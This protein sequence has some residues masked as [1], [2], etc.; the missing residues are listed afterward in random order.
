MVVDVAAQ[1][2][3]DRL[4]V[5]QR[6]VVGA[7]D[8]VEVV[9]FEHQVVDLRWPA[10]MGQADG[11]MARVAVQELDAERRLGVVADLEA[12][13]VAVQVAQL[14]EVLGDQ[15]DM[16]QAHVAGAETA[17][18][19]ARHEGRGG[20]GQAVADLD[21]QAVRVAEMDHPGDRAQADFLG[22]PRRGGV[23]GLLQR[24]GQAL[25]F[26]GV[27]HLEAHAHAR[28]A[29]GLADQQAL[30]LLVGAQAHAAVR[31]DHLDLQADMLAGLVDPGLQV[32]GLHHHVTQCVDH[33]VVLLWVTAPTCRHPPTAWCR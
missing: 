22:R 16:P 31:R 30:R 3:A 27:G 15:G 19:A 29:L 18:R 7:A 14:V 11:V 26:G 5:D 1:G 17:Q 20:V 2:H 12:E 9:V 10:G 6:H 33:L 25:Q 28:L 13:D 8:V 4:R 32:R 21:A 24:S 23:A